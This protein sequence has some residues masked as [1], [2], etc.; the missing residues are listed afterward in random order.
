MLE[1]LVLDL[2]WTLK[3][4]GLRWG[5]LERLGTAL[6]SLFLAGRLDPF[7]VEAPA[8]GSS[9][10]VAKDPEG[11]PVRE[12]SAKAIGCHTFLDQ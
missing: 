1:E 5:H 3:V 6:S 10:N 7:H 8:V 12:T 11:M 4:C 9:L 2:G